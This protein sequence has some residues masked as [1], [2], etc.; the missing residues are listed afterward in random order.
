MYQPLIY[1]ADICPGPSSQ[2]TSP[3]RFIQEG[4]EISIDEFSQNASNFV[5]LASRGRTW[6]DVMEQVLHERAH[7]WEELAAL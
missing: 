5:I 3:W 6:E 4:Y 2:T 1:E 7:T